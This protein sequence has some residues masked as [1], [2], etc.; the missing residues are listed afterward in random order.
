[1]PRPVT[2]VGV[3]REVPGFRITDIRDTGLFLPT[4]VNAPTTSVAARINGD[5]ELARRTLVEHLTKIDPN[6]GNIVTMRTLARLETFFLQIAFWVSIALGGLA[7]LLTVSGLFSVLSYLVEQRTREIGVRMALGA[8]PQNVTRLILMQTT[9]PVA[10][11]LLAG[12]GLAVALATFLLNTRVGAMI[13]EIVRVTDPIAYVASL[14]VIVAAC[15][16]AAWI[17]ATRAAHLNPMRT[18]RQE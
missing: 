13:A 17:P 18:L 16:L 10:Y 9:K 11:G 14:L 12:A 2:V 5:A 1:M 7:L 15:L 6:M 4:N 3:S 8:T